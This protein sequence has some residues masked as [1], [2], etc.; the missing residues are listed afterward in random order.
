MDTQPSFTWI[1]WTADDWK[2]MGE[3][4]SSFHEKFWNVL[5]SPLPL[6]LVNRQREIQREMRNHYFCLQKAL[7]CN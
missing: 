4:S 7:D 3:K 1:G 2:G 6:L 5:F